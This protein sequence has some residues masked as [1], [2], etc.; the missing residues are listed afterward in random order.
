MDKIEIKGISCLTY[1]GVPHAE[2][3]QL[4]EL[5]VDVTLE[6]DL[7]RAAEQD[8]FSETVDYQKIVDL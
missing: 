3:E 5:H 8:S 4:Q 2:R 6:A 7:A 1:I